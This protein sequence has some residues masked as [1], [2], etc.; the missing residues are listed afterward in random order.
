M[1]SER[2]EGVLVGSSPE[3]VS[4]PQGSMSKAAFADWLIPR[5]VGLHRN[6]STD[7]VAR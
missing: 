6:R 7:D 1:E 5:L 2:I 3:P 4:P